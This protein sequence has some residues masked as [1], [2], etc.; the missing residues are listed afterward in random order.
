[1][2][3]GNATDRLLRDL[4]QGAGCVHHDDVDAIAA[5]LERLVADPPP[6]VAPEDLQPWD[7]AGITARYA[8]LLE[9]LVA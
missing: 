1:V 2:D 3:P 9:A 5:A 6:P 4:G 7:R 8:E